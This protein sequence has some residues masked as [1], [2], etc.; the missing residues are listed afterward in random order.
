MTRSVHHRS[1][2]NVEGQI[3]VLA[4]LMFVILIGF[5]G[6]AI[7]VSGAYLADRWQRSVADAAALAGG[8]DL[9]VP[10]SRALP[11][12]ADYTRAKN[13]AMQILAFE[14]NADPL[15]DANCFNS[16]GCRLKKGGVDTPYVVAIQAPSPSCVDCEPARAIQVSVRQP[17]F[18]L[19]FARVFGQGSW[20]VNATSVAG[21]VHAR[22][23]GV[24]TL[25]PPDPRTNFDANEDDLS[26][27]GGS[28]VVVGQADVVTNTNLVCP[29]TNSRIVLDLSDGFDI[30][31][32]DTYTAWTQTNKTCTNPPPGTHIT[33]P[34]D[35]PGYAIPDR[36][37]A[38][39]QA[40]PP[41]TPADPRVICVYN[42]EADAKD[43]S[44]A[45][46]LAQQALVP[47]VYRELKTNLP[48][49]D[50]DQVTAAC[51][52]PGIYKFT[53]EAKNPNSGPP[54]A[55]LLEPGV[56]FFDYGVRVQSTLVG[57]YDPG[58]PGV[59][60]VF[61]EAQNASGD[62]GQFTTTNNTSLLA[63]NFGDA[64]C[65][66]AAGTTCSGG[67]WATAAQGPQGLVQTPGPRSVILSVMVVPIP[68]CRVGNEAP[69]P[70]DCKTS[71]NKTLQLTGGG[72]IFLAG[73]QY[74]P[75]DNAVLTGNAG[76]RS[77]IGAF[78]AWTLK[79]SGGTQFNLRS[80]NPEVTGVLRLDPACSP[81]VNVCNP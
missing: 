56:Y 8:Q 76:Q 62:P 81:T 40:C 57:G 78:W 59:A 75:S 73:V 70:T 10:G 68:G 65:P 6:L 25:R 14:L 39:L 71:E 66:G 58:Q 50:K 9:Q 30:Y 16:T 2:V 51:F 74:A 61:K 26:I 4:A 48:I 21:M 31:Y 49:N 1:Q 55:V 53:L 12:P 52:R 27:A 32:F 69:P 13:H 19:T 15:S 47:P 20:N 3:L 72:N 46:C 54:T 60:L 28:Q 41:G 34:V 42:S 11:Q 77:D 63:I 64:Y 17:S 18:G 33:S 45:N 80:S 5:V 79:F 29:G 24:V 35:I 37:A 7:D 44:S 38:T 67:Q 43:P 23:F 22:Q 36:T